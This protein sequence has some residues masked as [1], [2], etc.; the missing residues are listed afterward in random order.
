MKKGLD[1]QALFCY[2]KDTKGKGNNTMEPTNAEIIFYIVL[3]IISLGVIIKSALTPNDTI[4]ITW[5]QRRDWER[6]EKE[7]TK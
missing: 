6:R 2:N 5:G 7:W 1:K 4:D 3:G